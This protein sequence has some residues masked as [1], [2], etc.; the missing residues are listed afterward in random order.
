MK[1][2]SKLAK[3]IVV[4]VMVGLMLGVG[5]P[6]ATASKNAPVRMI[7]QNF[8]DLAATVSPAVVHIQVE[9]TVKG[10]SPAFG[11]FGRNP[12][13]GN[14]Q[15]K[16]FF[17]RNFGEQRQP[18]F[19]QPAQGS[20][21]I[22]EKSG[23]IVTNNHVVSGADKITVI[24]KDETKY[25]AKVIGLDPVTDIALIKVEPKKDL[26]VVSMGSSDDLKVGEW[27]VAIGAPFGLEYTVTAGIVSAKG[28]VIG[29]GPYD[30]FIQ[31]DASINPGNS[32]GPLINMQGEVVGINTMIIAGGQ[33]IGFAIPVDQ[34]KGII[35]QLE[36]NGEVTRGWLGVTIQD[37]NEDLADYYGLKGKSGAM[38]ADVVP[39]DPADKAGIKPKDIITEVNGK[40]VTSSR[41]LTKLAANLQVGETA[42]VT[43][44]RDGKPQTL[45]VKIGKRPL[46]IAAASQNYGEEKKGEYGFQV[47]DLTPEVARQFNVDG[48]AGVIVVGVA[49]DSKADAAGIKK[50]DIIVEV[51]RVSVE[52]VKDF[53]SLLDQHKNSDGINLLV[54]RMNAGLIVI[55]LA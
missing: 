17:G 11:P 8:S 27:V 9:K 4:L 18:E 3:Y 29:S 44:L 6:M 49:P 31:T 41:D 48:T 13:G 22:I 30:D 32:G 36:T 23:L 25:D 21:F 46:T 2:T 20:G 40:V 28:R 50:G 26:P 53:K 12:F 34:A 24:L 5:L 16:D 10:G 52:S 47:T 33:G 1:Q 42:S 39:G 54:K 37:L 15:F 35:A 14:E 7:P 51:N 19:K 43:I 45:D 55:H 38:V